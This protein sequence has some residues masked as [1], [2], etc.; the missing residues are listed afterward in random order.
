MAKLSSSCRLFRFTS[1]ENAFG[2]ILRPRNF[3]CC[4]AFCLYSICKEEID[5][6]VFGRRSRPAYSRCRGILVLPAIIGLPFVWVQSHLFGPSNRPLSLVTAHA[7][8]SADTLTG[9]L[10]VAYCHLLGIMMF[11]SD[12]FLH[13]F[14]PLHHEANQ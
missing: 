11:P 6:S 3:K 12:H 1:A 5:E 14:S 13:S 8:L 9:V 4:S 7:P 10:I 2:R